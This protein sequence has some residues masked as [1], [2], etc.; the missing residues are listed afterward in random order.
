MPESR[1]MTAEEVRAEWLK[2]PAVP[3]PNEPVI[4]DIFTYHAPE[5]DQP[6]RYKR[7][8]AKAKELA[9]VIH[10]ACDP[11]PERTAA[12]RHLREAVMT[13]NQS[14]ATNNAQYR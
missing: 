6:E 13:A 1:Q 5:G 12:M 8:R 11:G 3:M 7:I 9:Y 10:W 4:E 2:D 14:I